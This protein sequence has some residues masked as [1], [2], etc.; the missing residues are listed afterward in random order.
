MLITI[1]K[2]VPV[3]V[4]LLFALL[5]SLGY[6]QSRDRSVSRARIFLVPAIMAPW[7]LYSVVAMYK[8]SNLSIALLSWLM[9]ISLAIALHIY[10]FGS[11]KSIRFNASTRRYQVPGSWLPLCLM[12]VI[13]LAR[14]V[15]GVTTATQPSVAASDTFTMIL[16]CILGACSGLFISR[17]V[18]MLRT[19]ATSVA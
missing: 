8:S 4:W 19:R 18:N 5:L 3:W 15:S 11:I 9:G 1:L 6:M 16:C 10:L 17:A 12:L 2:N 14:F 7:S 13:F